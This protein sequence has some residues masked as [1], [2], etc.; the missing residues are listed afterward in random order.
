MLLEQDFGKKRP[1]IVQA[2]SVVIFISLCIIACFTAFYRNGTIN[3][4][5]L[6]EICCQGDCQGDGVIDIIMFLKQCPYLNL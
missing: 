2:V 3:I 5:P 1:L 4:S 6:A